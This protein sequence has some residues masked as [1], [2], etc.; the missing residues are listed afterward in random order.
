[1]KVA[2]IEDLIKLKQQGMTHKQIAKGYGVSYPVVQGWFKDPR[3]AGLKA[4]QAVNKDV[5]LS[6]V[7]ADG[8]EV[9][10]FNPE[11]ANMPVK[12]R[13]KRV[14]A[15]AV[16]EE[17]VVEEAPAVGAPA[18]EAPVVETPAVENNTDAPATDEW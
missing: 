9:L 1:M 3:L 16:E 18:V 2:L 12:T 4:N 10:T 11:L 15:P 17:P 13:A 7:A 8:Q 6:D 14:S 5:K